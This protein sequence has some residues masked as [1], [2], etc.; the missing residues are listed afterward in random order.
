MPALRGA[1]KGA[2]N[3]GHGGILTVPGTVGARWGTEIANAIS[4]QPPGFRDFTRFLNRTT[5]VGAYS[6]VRVK[7]SYN[8]EG[9][10]KAQKTLSLRIDGVEPP[11]DLSSAPN[12]FEF[13]P[14]PFRVFLVAC[15]L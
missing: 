2:P 14:P 9:Q 6:Y 15:S 12:H 3:A 10:D 7:Y 1:P 11:S 5:S 13:E 4:R 8:K